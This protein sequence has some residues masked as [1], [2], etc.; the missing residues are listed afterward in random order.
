MATGK[1]LNGKPYAGNPR[2][3][4]P[5]CHG[6]ASRF[7]EEAGA[8]CTA[9]VSL[10][11]THCRMQPEGRANVCAATPRRGSPLCRAL[12]V[13][14]LCVF[15]VLLSFAEAPKTTRYGAR[16]YRRHRVDTPPPTLKLPEKW[17]LV[18]GDE[19]VTGCDRRL[20]YFTIE[21]DGEAVP[22]PTVAVSWPGVEISSVG[23]AS[24]VKKT[25]DGVALKPTGKSG[26]VNYITSVSD[27][28]ITLGIHHHV[29]GAQHGRY[30]GR[31]LP[32]TQI[33]ASD[34]WRAA[35]LAMFKA[36]GIASLED[37]DGANIR[38]FGFDSN[39]PQHH[40]DYP[41]HFHVML[42]WG[43]WTYNNVGHYI[44]D[45]NG[46]IT[47]NDFHSIGEIAGGLPKGVYTHKLGE[48][49]NYVGPKGRACFSLELARDGKSLVLHKP[50]TNAVWRVCSEDPVRSVMMEMR[51]GEDG[52]WIPQGRYFA[53]DDTEKG[54]YVIVGED[55][56]A[57]RKLVVSY[58]RDTGGLL[59][60]KWQ[61]VAQA[62][63]ISPAAC[64]PSM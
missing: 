53:T 9:G 15:S 12:M 31:P 30:G 10:R 43:G 62:D 21:T 38:L 45:K 3:A 41:E 61:E 19:G 36:A 51:N 26:G 28:A 40:V 39:Y 34:N 7:D 42:A 35:C 22:P 33:R 52:A 56:G 4:P 8:S 2:V 13:L 14:F 60:V 55:K 29:E 16:I 44:L 64:A 49:T 5:Q 47:K 1:A 57:V 59:S 54:E 32:W 48:T 25:A 18:D 27:G 24:N 23:G 6:A 50:G 11:R 46:L 58:N 17:R 37:T 20:Y 63:H